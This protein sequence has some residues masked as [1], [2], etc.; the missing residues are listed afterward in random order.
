ML[1]QESLLLHPSAQGR[2]SAPWANVTRSFPY[3]A[4]VTQAHN[5]TRI[6]RGIRRHILHSCRKSTFKVS[7]P[8]R[9]SYLTPAGNRGLVVG[10]PRVR[11]ATLGYWMQLLRSKGY[12]EDS[13]HLPEVHSLLRRGTVRLRSRP[14]QTLGYWMQLLRSKGNQN[15]LSRRLRSRFCRRFGC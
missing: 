1:I 7:V 9:L 12:A 4:R 13:I 14:F 15:Q 3:P 6:A 5:P 10:H 11:C 2:A 8:R